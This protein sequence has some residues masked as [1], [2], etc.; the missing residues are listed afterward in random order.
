MK[1][2]LSG[3]DPGTLGVKDVDQSAQLSTSAGSLDVSELCNPNSSPSGARNQPTSIAEKNLTA[4][5]SCP[6][7]VSPD[8]SAVPPPNMVLCVCVCVCVHVMIVSALL[9]SLALYRAHSSP[10]PLL[11]LQ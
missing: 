6:A 5:Q 4:S 9:L 3:E 11:S 2:I 8:Q 10:P 7:P 1:A